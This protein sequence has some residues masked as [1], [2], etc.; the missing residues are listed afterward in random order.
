MAN[1]FDF[2]N[3]YSAYTGGYG[4]RTSPTITPDEYVRELNQTPM[5][6]M[7]NNDYYDRNMEPHYEYE[8]ANGGLL[9]GYRPMYNYSAVNSYPYNMYPMGGLYF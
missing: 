8:Y 4:Y 3:Q 2:K 5:Y 1:N 9:R 6:N 7:Y